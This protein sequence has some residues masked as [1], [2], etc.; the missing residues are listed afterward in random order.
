MSDITFKNKVLD[1]CSDMSD[2]HSKIVKAICLTDCLH[3]GSDLS[4]QA[5]TV[6]GMVNSLLVDADNYLQ[7]LKD[8]EK[9]QAEREA[10]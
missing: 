9:I 5:R 10:A 8:M 6:I 2:M 1:T 4:F 3:D 7:E